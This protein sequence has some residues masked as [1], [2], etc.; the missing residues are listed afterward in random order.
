MGQFMVS[1]QL[2]TTINSGAVSGSHSTVKPRVGSFATFAPAFFLIGA[3]AVAYAD[4]TPDYQ[5]EHTW[6]NYENS[7]SSTTKAGFELLKHQ[8]TEERVIARLDAIFEDLLASQRDLDAEDQ[9]AIAKR[10]WQLYE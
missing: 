1:G 3:G 5:P 2:V 6:V 8:S 9:K 10:L 7:L 4:P